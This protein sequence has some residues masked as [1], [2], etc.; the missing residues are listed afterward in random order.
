MQRRKEGY[1]I[2]GT[3]LDT[4]T[5][6]KFIKSDINKNQESYK[7]P[8]S[9]ECYPETQNKFYMSPK[10]VQ[11]ERNINVCL[12]EYAKLNYLKCTSSAFCWE[13]DNNILVVLF[14]HT[15]VTEKFGLLES[16]HNNLRVTINIEVKTSSSKTPT[17]VST[18]EAYDEINMKV[19]E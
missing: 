19:V 17:L 1:A 18:V 8:F 13:Q 16:G 7:S 11:F 3:E 4:K 14:I 2:Q 5:G 15:P 6:K 9:Q 12:E 10:M